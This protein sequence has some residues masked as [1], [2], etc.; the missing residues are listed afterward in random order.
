MH[1]IE[2]L[3]TG[4]S[5]TDKLARTLLSPFEMAFRGIVAVRGR[6]YE[7][8]TLEITR[9]PIQVVSVGNLTV[10]G[11][12]KTPISAWLASRLAADGRSPA[13]VLRGYGGDES[14]VHKVLNPS[15]PVVVASDRVAGIRV[16]AQGGADVA[17]L[18]D[19]FQHRRAARDV[20]IV[21]VSAD[22]WTGKQRLLPAGPYREP[23][24]SLQRASIVVITRKGAADEKVA[25][26]ETFVRRTAPAVIVCVAR[27]DLDGL[28]SHSVA[29]EKLDMRALS[30]KSVFAIAAIGNAR[31]LFSQIEAIGT[32]V[33]RREFPDHHA[34]TRSEIATLAAEGAQFD[35]VVCTLKDAVKLGPHWPADASPLWYV[36]LSVTVERGE[37]AIDEILS[38]LDRSRDP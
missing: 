37:A 5:P 19:A 29:Q 26:V 22:D 17:I 20:D 35:F 10:G 21:L 24:D 30:G 8:G 14:R 36:S 12:G 25:S 31:A 6:L 33:E 7:S 3:W 15:V 9:S 16:A 27:L 23:V 32:R 13:I 34:F 38:R 2:R 28:V 1:I 18:D 11:T 4:E